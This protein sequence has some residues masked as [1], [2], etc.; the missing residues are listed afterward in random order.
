M[1]VQLSSRRA[2]SKLPNRATVRFALE[3]RI[4][5]HRNCTL[6]TG[7]TSYIFK[8]LDKLLCL[9]SQF[10]IF[11]DTAQ[12]NKNSLESSVIFKCVQGSWDQNIWELP[13]C[14]LAALKRKKKNPESIQVDL[15]CIIPKILMPVLSGVLLF[16]SPRCLP[17]SLASGRWVPEWHHQA[18][19]LPPLDSWSASSAVCS[20]SI[21]LV[22][23]CLKP[24]AATRRGPAPLVGSLGACC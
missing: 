22:G 9:C 19:R 10:E 5:V 15:A 11:I 3:N 4:I 8:R 6:C 12:K 13:S 1:R 14:I 20:V 16:A 18:K 2:L 23:E 17:S 24:I 21:W 7:F